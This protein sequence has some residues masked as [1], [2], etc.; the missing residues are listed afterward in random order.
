MK[1]VI[2]AMALLCAAPALAETALRAGIEAMRPGIE[3]TRIAVR[4][5]LARIIFGALVLVPDHVI[6]GGDFLEFLL[7]GG[8]SRVLVGMMFLGERAERLLDVGLAGAFGHAQ[9]FVGVSHSHSGGPASGFQNGAPA[10]AFA[11]ARERN[12]TDRI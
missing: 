5:D 10:V 7:R 1:S 3:T 4:S 9:D 6:G 11:P 2:V 8:V 12:H